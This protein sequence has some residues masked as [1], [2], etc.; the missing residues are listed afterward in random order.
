MRLRF[1]EDGRPIV[2]G[3][4]T[5]KLVAAIGQL[6]PDQRID[7]ESQVRA[8]SEEV[9]AKLL[10]ASLAHHVQYE[11]VD[12]ADVPGPTNGN[13]YLHAWGEAAQ[14]HRLLDE[15]L[16]DLALVDLSPELD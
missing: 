9:Q 7:F 8:Q 11:L 2:G 3:P 4:V 13:I 5:P 12:H 14:I 6:P 16:P 15:L 10:R 1:A